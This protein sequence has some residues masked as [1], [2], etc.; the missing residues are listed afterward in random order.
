MIQRHDNL[1][2]ESRSQHITSNRRTLLCL[3]MSLQCS[4]TLLV[5]LFNEHFTA[6]YSS[7][8]NHEFNT[9][10]TTTVINSCEQEVLKPGT[11][12]ERSLRIVSLISVFDNE[13]VLRRWVKFW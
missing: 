5:L 13:V 8:V 11:V 9:I 10:M 1:V 6:K 2:L 7:R 12:V 4:Q 3:C